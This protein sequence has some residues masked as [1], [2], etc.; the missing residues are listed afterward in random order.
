MDYNYI[1]NLAAIIGV[2]HVT[3]QPYRVV[4]DNLRLMD[5]VI[6]FARTQRKLKRFLYPSTSEVTMGT[7]EYFDLLIPTPENTPPNYS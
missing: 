7:M 2:E 4:V 5:N 1:F 3:R 6:E